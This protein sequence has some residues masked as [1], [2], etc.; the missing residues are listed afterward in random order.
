MS[1]FGHVQQVYFRHVQ[2]VCF[3]YVQQV[4]CGAGQGAWTEPRILYQHT[5]A[6]APGICALAYPPAC[7]G[8]VS[9]VHIGSQPARVP[10]LLRAGSAS[11]LAQ[12]CDPMWP[13]KGTLGGVYARGTFKHGCTTKGL[14]F[15]SIEI[16]LFFSCVCP[17][18]MPGRIVILSQACQT[19]R[20]LSIYN[21]DELGTPTSMHTLMPSASNLPTGRC[22]K[23]TPTQCPA[24]RRRWSGVI[25]GA[26][27]GYRL[28]G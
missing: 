17:G 3:G 24:Q 22:L 19:Q 8:V 27:A 4:C 2:Q 6:N 7:Q 18:R 21:A 1:D 20:H 5:K 26:G 12:A 11:L 16:D 13:G 9:L 23:R 15:V 14:F 25:S 10:C 28:A